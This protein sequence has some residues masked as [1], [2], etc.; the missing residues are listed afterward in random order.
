MTILNDFVS[1]LAKP[2][3][4]GDS[5]TNDDQLQ[6]SKLINI[7]ESVEKFMDLIGVFQAAREFRQRKIMCANSDKELGG[8]DQMGKR[9]FEKAQRL[10]LSERKNL[11]KKI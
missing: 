1:T 8:A 4:L 5:R 7:K 11:R 9:E 3:A 10:W 6:G 2:L